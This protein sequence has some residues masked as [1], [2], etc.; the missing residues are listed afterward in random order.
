MLALLGLLFV[1]P[2]AAQL[3]TPP[4][5]GCQYAVGDVYDSSGGEHTKEVVER[6]DGSKIKS[7]AQLAAYVQMADGKTILI[8]G[9]DFSAWDFTGVKLSNICFVKSDLSKSNWAGVTATGLGFIKSNVESAIMSGA[10]MTDIL[11]RSSVFARVDATGAGWTSGKLDGGWDGDVEQLKLDGADLTGFRFDCGITVPDGCPLSRSGISARGAKLA[12]SDWSSFGFYGADMTG[13]ILNQTVISPRQLTDFKGA[14]TMG[15]VVLA[16]GDE[17]VMVLP[18]TWTVLMASAL[19]AVQADVPSFN[20]AD[21]P[22][23]IET[24]VCAGH[25]SNLRQYD[26]K[27]AAL[28]KEARKRGIA[29]SDSQ[30]AWLAKRNSCAA[31]QS[32]GECLHQAYDQRVGQL[33]GLLG[34]SDWLMAEREA[35]FLEEVLPLGDD[36]VRSSIYDQLVPVLA[37]EARSSL[38]VKRSDDG[39]IEAYGDAVGANAHIC[40]LRV[41]GLRFDAAT[42]WYSIAASEGGVTRNVPVLRYYDGRIEIYHSGRLDDG[43]ELPPMGDA[44]NNVSCGARAS[45]PPMVKMAVPADLMAQYRRAA[46]E[47]M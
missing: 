29:V 24:E 3:P 13:A 45:F 30:K 39:S 25:N 38:L 21:A 4:V 43:E 32:P 17:K 36:V 44:R 37:G 11:I 31:H 22:T 40:S 19:E 42:G 6:Y 35:L 8:E 5:P 14:A 18:E 34:E 47:D 10:Q 26:R 1:V 28:Y 27:M 41:K 15:P 20:C 7:P 12:F 23:A 2:A 46:E 33:I 16:G 9:G